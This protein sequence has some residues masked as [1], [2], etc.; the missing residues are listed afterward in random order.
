MKRTMRWAAVPAAAL[1]A[2]LGLCA[3]PVQAGQAPRADYQ[4]IAHPVVGRVGETV[5]VELGVRNGG[6]G[7]AGGR[8]G[9]GAGTY[10]VTPPPGTAIV[11][12][13]HSGARQPCVAAVSPDAAPGSYI[14]SI[15][16]NF[17][18]GERDTLSFRVRIDEK[19][20]GAEGLVRILAR[21]GEPSP[22]P[23]PGNDTAP[24]RVE[25]VDRAP[26][27]PLPASPATNST[28]LLATT[29]GTAVSA[30]A[31]AFGVSRRKR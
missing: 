21:D 14:C 30:G 15:G 22:D 13:P 8:P 23:D 19:V 7:P 4:A 1:A 12:A 24:I 26:E 11:A 17:S 25:V 16:E 20:D 5:E 18:A 27:P 31:I 29:S 9:H 6:P 10:E 3:A 28:L 2:G